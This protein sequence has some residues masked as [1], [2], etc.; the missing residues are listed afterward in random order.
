GLWMRK[1]VK[2]RLKTQNMYPCNKKNKMHKYSE[3]LVH[4]YKYG[5]YMDAH[6]RKGGFYFGYTFTLVK[7]KKT[8]LEEQR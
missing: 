8:C 1:G 2:R 7:Y 4:D 3:V 6:G 5:I